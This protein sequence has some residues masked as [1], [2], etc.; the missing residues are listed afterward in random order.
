MLGRG[1]RR[2]RVCFYGGTKLGF[3]MVIGGTE[4]YGCAGEENIVVLE[5]EGGEVVTT[6]V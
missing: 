6:M 1:S 3:K 4:C 2:Q 5:G